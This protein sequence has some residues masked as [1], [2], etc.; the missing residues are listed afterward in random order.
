[1]GLSVLIAVL[2]MQ[3]P[4]PS[5]SPSASPRP[6]AETAEAVIDRLE[7]ERKDPCLKAAR[8]KVPCFPAKTEQRGFD[9]SVRQSLGL[10][11][12]APDKPASGGA[13]TVGEMDPYRPHNTKPAVSVTFDP[14]CVGR[15]ALKKLKGKNDTYFLYRIRDI[16]G[17]RV[18]LFD[19]KLDATTV[20]GNVAFLGKFDGECEAQA[21][22]RHEQRRT[23]APPSPA[24]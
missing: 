12:A 23:P 18:V 22:Y 8:E 20:Q 21:A 16:H 2:M 1:V 6:I 13:P 15:S 7:A 3:S 11:D 9:A 14:V 4:S 24:P 19:H 5:P 10:P 17:E